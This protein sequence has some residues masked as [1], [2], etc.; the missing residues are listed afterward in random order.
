M[1]KEGL[2]ITGFIEDIAPLD[3]YRQHLEP[4]DI[5]A[6]GKV[7]IIG[8]GPACEEVAI[9][10]PE[11]A[12]GNVT[13]IDVI[14]GDP[15]RLEDAK[16]IGIWPESYPQFSMSG[17]S[18]G[19]LYDKYPRPMFDTIM[20]IG[21]PMSDPEMSLNLLSQLLEQQGRLYVTVN[22]RVPEKLDLPGFNVKII[23]EIPPNPNY[24]PLFLRYYG[25][26]VER[27]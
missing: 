26:V 5:Q 23:P 10:E 25:V 1:N 11:I 2:P 17:L 7:L 20:F 12:S 22:G 14:N 15:F 16:A 24:K 13:K 6:K 27:N 4:L 8:P 18:Y 3:E 19:H 9:I 21:T